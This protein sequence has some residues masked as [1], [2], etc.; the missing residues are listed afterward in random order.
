M[1]VSYIILVCV[2]LFMICSTVTRIFI[3]ISTSSRQT[4][5]PISPVQKP[6]QYTTVFVT[7]N[8]LFFGL[9][10]VVFVGKLMAMVK[11]GK[12]SGASSSSSSSLILTSGAS[13]RINALFSVQ[14]LKSLFMLINAFVLLLLVPFRGRRRTAVG[15]V[16][17][18]SSSSSSGEK[19][20][21]ERMQER[22]VVQRK[23]TMVRVPATIVPWKSSGGGGGAAAAVDQEVAARRALAIRRVLQDDDPNTVREFS[24]FVTAR[25]DTIF[26]QSWT[27]VYAK[28]R[29]CWIEYWGFSFN[30]ILF[31]FYGILCSLIGCL[32][33]NNVRL[34]WWRDFEFFIC[35]MIVMVFE[36]FIQ[37]KPKKR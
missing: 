28:I 6:K 13:G 17:M 3:P 19:S 30:W 29:Y 15:P 37:L 36:F 8:Q 25:G 20:K 23:G 16:A 33:L 21:D 12:I 1:W 11:S 27:P 14:T 32:A 5:I 4:K 26:T 2:C 35:Y 9:K 24:L 10:E 34:I 22:A 18:S 31:G 7:K